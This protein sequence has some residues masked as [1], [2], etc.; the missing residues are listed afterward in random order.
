MRTV[1][2]NNIYVYSATKELYFWCKDNLVVTNPTYETLMRLGKQDQITRRH[3]QKD[4]KLFVEKNVDLLSGGCGDLILPVGCLYAIWPMIKNYPYELRFNNAGDISCKEDVITQPLFDYQEEAVQKMLAAK[5]GVLIGGTGS[6][7]TNCGIEIIHRLGKKFLWLTHTKDLVRQS[8]ERMKKLYPRMQVGIVGDGK[9][10]FGRDGTIAT[11]QTMVTLDPDLY[12]N[13]FDVVV[14]DE[15]HHVAQSPEL[16]RMF[17]KVLEKIPA[18]HKY[19][20]TASK[21][22]NDSLTKTIYATV[23]CNPAGEF[24]PVWFIKKSDTATLTAEHVKV[25]LDTPFCYEMLNPDGTF[26]FPA[27]V[28]YLAE[29]Q[30]RNATIV[31]K[32]VECANV[33]EN[34]QLVLCSRI[35]QCETLHNMLLEKGIKSELLVGKVTSK[36]REK[37]LKE[38]V[39]WQVIVATVSLAK[40][41]LDLPNLNILHLASCIGNESDTIQ[42]VG[43]IERFKE[44]KGTPVAYDYVDMHIPYLV[45]RYKKRVNWLR[46]RK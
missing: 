16:Q 22:R 23:G 14:C 1:I 4:M 27:L 10:D 34:K 42:S 7:K 28:D 18:R 33:P 24:A 3:V 46:R 12:K 25:E 19:G 30:E 8:Y 39:D 32:I 2:S 9:L 36:K 31:D 17:G 43:R 35:S 29:N 11:I 13:D 20:L 15:V 6:G 38:Q 45:S 40:E 41:G 44:G 37:I 26:N 21:N 5:S